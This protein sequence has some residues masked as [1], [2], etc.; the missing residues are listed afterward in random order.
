L[1]VPCWTLYA[2]DATDPPPV[3]AAVPAIGLVQFDDVN[4]PELAGVVIVAVGAVLSTV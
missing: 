2:T 3:S 1:P 4:G